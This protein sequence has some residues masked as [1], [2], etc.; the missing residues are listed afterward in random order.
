MNQHEPLNHQHHR[1]SSAAYRRESLSNVTP[2]SD[3]RQRRKSPANPIA[4]RMRVLYLKLLRLQDK[5]EVVAKGLAVGIFAGCFPF[6]GIQSLLGIFLATIC[7]GSKVAALA[8]T[9]ISNPLTY[10]PLYVFNYKI[11]KLLLGIEDTVV[12]PLDL[13]SFTTFREQGSTFAIALLAG[14]FVVGAS[15]ATL[16]YFYS[17]AILERWR[18]RSIRRRN[19][20]RRK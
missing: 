10:V 3:P 14:S 15:L 5:P 2:P 7:R 17:L 11:G 20:K 13:E 8:A 6:F 9:W 16:S 12:L 19:L 4:R 1:Q 18:D